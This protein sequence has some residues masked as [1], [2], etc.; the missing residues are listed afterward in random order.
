MKKIIN[1]VIRHNRISFVLHQLN[2]IGLITAI[3]FFTIAFI[4]GC[5]KESENKN[6]EEMQM[7]MAK[8][9]QADV[10]NAYGDLSKPTLWE[11]QQAR[12]ATAKYRN[13]ENA[14][15]DGYTDIAVDVEHMGHHFMKMSIVDSIF[16]IKQPE[17]LVYNKD[18]N[19]NQQLVA[20][21]Y[22]VP[23]SYP[24]PEGFTGWDDV[25]NDTSGFPL[26]L[27]H[28]WVW[29]YNPDGVFHWTN[30]SVHLH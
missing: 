1:G 2:H 14:I 3:G 8:N 11:L 26:W 15:K 18:E 7:P 25:W 27:L 4:S 21:E 28:A 29:A 16:D 17:I 5:K 20:V 23:L 22:A 13:I 10:L 12:A 19:G 30:S 6:V 24:M 9:S